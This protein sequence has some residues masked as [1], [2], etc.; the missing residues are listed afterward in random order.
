MRPI[1]ENTLF[2]GD[3]L[4]ILREHIP[5]ESVDLI[6]LDPPFNS[7]RSYNVLFREETGIESE[8]QITAFEDTWHW[9]HVAEETYQELVTQAPEHI[10]QMISALRIFI[11]TNQMMA[12]LV[13]M[14]VRL[15]ELHRV[16]K[17]T[18]SLYLHCDPTASHYLKIIL[19]T[20]FGVQNYRSEITWLR[21]K[22]PKGSQHEPKQYSP[23]TDIILFYAKSDLAE[24]HTLRIKTKLSPQ[25]LAIKYDRLDEKGAFTD[26][27]IL[28]SPSMGDRPNLVYEYKGYTPGPFGWRVELDKLVEIDRKGNLGWSSTGQPYR[29]LRPEE[30][31]GNPVG[32]CWMDISS[33]NPQATERLGYPTQKPLPLLERIIQASSNPGD[34]VLDP[35][36]GCGTSIAAAQKLDRKWIGIDITHLS[37][38]LMKYR[39]EAMF[40]GIKFKVIG[41][42]TDISAARQLA[43]DEEG[44]YQFQ[45]WALSL[46][47][48]KPLGGQEGSREGKKGSDK[49]VDGLIA[50]I[51]DNT[52]KAKRVIVQVKSGHVN[53][54]QIGELVGTVQREQA[55]IGVFITLEPPS[56]DMK[57]EAVSAG[58]YHSPG[59]NKDYPH[60][61]IL[62]IEELLHGAEVKMPPQFGTFKQ[63]QK[64]GKQTEAEQAELGLS[65]G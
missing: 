48:A 65:T 62:T 2:Y 63:A 49:G 44:R 34:I 30:D 43:K 9:N 5:S 47:R 31:T 52:G 12:Y 40:P 11:G 25:Q 46:I 24:L 20:I 32:N 41:E 35:F 22:N 37:I 23:D 27:P 64:V 54:G 4:F 36:C 26:G 53:R 6:Y 8:A 61:Q 59:W 28:R 10:S 3:N 13:M 17:P 16:L 38:A 57:T 51:D 33:I 14:A 45:W 7:S 1:T 56:R 39:L 42:P 50:F 55:A 29:K 19:D 21:S 15:V 60:I 18:G 58:F